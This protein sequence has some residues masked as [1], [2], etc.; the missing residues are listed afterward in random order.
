M[1]VNIILTRLKL[2]VSIFNLFHPNRDKS[3]LIYSA[4]S[5]Q[6]I[7]EPSLVDKYAKLPKI[8]GNYHLQKPTA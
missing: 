5:D 6:R 3:I 7:I 8:F 1:L 2:G 4:V